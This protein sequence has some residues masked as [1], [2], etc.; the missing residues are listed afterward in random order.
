M[1]TT[2]EIHEGIKLAGIAM[3]VVF[4]LAIVGLLGTV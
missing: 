1:S 4:T 3:A 2:T